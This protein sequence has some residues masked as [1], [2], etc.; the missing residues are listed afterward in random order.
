MK[1]KK[2][3][4]REEETERYN[5]NGGQNGGMELNMGFLIYYYNWF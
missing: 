2:R 5:A 4:L 1:M 3:E